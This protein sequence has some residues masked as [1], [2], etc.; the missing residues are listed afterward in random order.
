M[1]RTGLLILVALAVLGGFSVCAKAERVRACN[2]LTIRPVVGEITEAKLEEVDFDLDHL[3]CAMPTS[4]AKRIQAEYQAQTREYALY[5]VGEVE[6]EE[7]QAEEE[8]SVTEPVYADESGWQYYGECR[9]TFYDDCAE[10]CGVAGNATA[11][12][13]YPTA[14]VTVASG[15]D[16]PFGTEVTIGGEVYVVQDRGVGPYQIDIFVSDHDTAVA[17]GMYYT[18]V[19]VKYSDG[20]DYAE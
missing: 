7:V 1:K 17:M 20:L 5:C 18:D 16:L 4:E 6:P 14:G 11:S 8:E 2:H 15:E 9:I 13:V 19:Y 12:G 10:C 3:S